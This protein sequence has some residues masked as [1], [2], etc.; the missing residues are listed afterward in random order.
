MN[1]SVTS[2]LT[3]VPGYI[4]LVF[5]SIPLLIPGNGYQVPFSEPLQWHNNGCHGV[6]NHWRLNCLLMCL[7]T[8][9]S[10]K[11]SKLCFT[12]LCEGNSPVTGEFPSQRASNAENVSIWWCNHDRVE[13]FIYDTII[14]HAMWQDKYRRWKNTG[15]SHHDIIK[16]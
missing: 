13:Q 10:K 11:T 4:P 14:V 7:S 1:K 15:F 6:S 5:L 12:G 16:S 8:H 9:R 3:R 2:S